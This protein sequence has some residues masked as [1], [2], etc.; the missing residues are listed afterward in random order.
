MGEGGLIV[1]SRFENSSRGKVG[2]IISSWFEKASGTSAA[3]ISGDSGSWEQELTT[4]TTWVSEMLEEVDKSDGTGATTA[5]SL[6]WN[7]T[8][9]LFLKSYSIQISK[10]LL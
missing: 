2:L 9:Y 10:Q 5:T 8:I 6:D 4:S 1:F 7:Q 3:F